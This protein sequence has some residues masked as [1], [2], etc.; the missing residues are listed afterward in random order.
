MLEMGGLLIG[1]R[2]YEPVMWKRKYPHFAS[3]YRIIA[4]M[5]RS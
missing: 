1:T 4:G 3:G 2:A 5:A